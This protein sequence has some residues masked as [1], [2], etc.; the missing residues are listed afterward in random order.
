MTTPETLRARRAALADALA[1]L[2]PAP[3]ATLAETAPATP[4]AQRGPA[5]R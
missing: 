1:L 3:V 2:Q 4:P 5:M